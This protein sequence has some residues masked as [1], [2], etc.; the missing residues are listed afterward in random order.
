MVVRKRKK[1]HGLR[2]SRTHGQGN[3]KNKRGAGSRGGRGKA[4][5]HKHKFATYW[6]Q[7]GTKIT[8]K[9]KK[10]KRAISIEALNSIIERKGEQDFEK[11]ESLLLLDG[12]KLGFEKVLGTG[13][14]EKKIFLLNA[15]AS[16]QARK[17]IEE[18]GGKIA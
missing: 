6:K 1:L 2:G 5:S 16:K 14:I 4:G 3:T 7:F 17:K 8:L 9:P 15:M 13:K 10:E 18:A 12:K 11:K